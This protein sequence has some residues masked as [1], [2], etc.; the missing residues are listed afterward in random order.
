MILQRPQFSIRGFFSEAISSILLV[1]RKLSIIKLLTSIF[2]S[3]LYYHTT[4]LT[5]NVSS[6]HA[7]QLE[8]ERSCNNSDE[9]LSRLCLYPARNWIKTKQTFFLM[10]EVL[11]WKCVYWSRIKYD[12]KPSHFTVNST[13][14]YCLMNC[15]QNILVC[16][17]RKT[18]DDIN[19]VQLNQQQA[20]LFV[21]QNKFTKDAQTAH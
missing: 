2:A 13:W 10:R 11:E 8:N 17:L 15:C 19:G 12:S 7:I 18:L 14:C 9:A 3:R 4:S 6:I 21:H 20:V 5:T 1:C 16:V